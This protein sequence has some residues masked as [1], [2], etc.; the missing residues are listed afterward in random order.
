MITV[1][2][3]NRKTKTYHTVN[4]VTKSNLKTKTY[5]TVNTIKKSNR[6][7]VETEADRPTTHIHGHSQLKKVTGLN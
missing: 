6:T 7:M 1:T 2:K 5:H 3:S 4:T